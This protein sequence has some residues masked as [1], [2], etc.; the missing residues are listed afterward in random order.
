MTQSEQ[1]RAERRWYRNAGGLRY[2]MA[3]ENWVVTGR[4][5]CQ[6]TRPA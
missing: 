1:S 2:H 5:E 3:G 4:S 6:V